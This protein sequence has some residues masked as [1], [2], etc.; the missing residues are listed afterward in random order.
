MANDEVAVA[1]PTAALADTV[2]AARPAP[3]ALPQLRYLLRSM[4]PRQWT[5]NGIVFLAL[6]FSVG[7][8]YHLTD[9]ST[10]IP[11]LLESLVAF[12]CFAMVSSADYLVNDIRDIEQDRVHP[13]KSKR[14]IAAGLLPVSTAWTAAVVLAVIGNAAAFALDWRVGLVVFAYTVLMVGYS[15]ALKHM[16]L[17]DLMVIATGF[18]LRAMAGA[19]AIDV[20]ISP[21]LYVVTALG[22]LFLGI[23]KRRA[24]LDLLQDGA[25]SHRKILDEYTP[26]LLDQ[27][28]STVTAATLMA[29]GLYTFT[30]EGLP[31]DH[32]MMLTIPFV[33]YGI[34]RYLYLVNVKKEGGSP[35]EVLLKDIPIIL[36]IVGWVA[37]AGIVLLVARG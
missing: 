8:Q 6:I 17:I 13:R 5:K 35:E 36:C 3:G 4:R 1:A 9:S 27:M 34:F 10:F 14:P 30:A 29:Y 18:V 26:E 15:Y 25:G 23:N 12:A 21:W 31:S 28:A 11:K 33:L 7:Q 2:A 19:L 16:V 37:T 22:A 32:S 20:P 24:E